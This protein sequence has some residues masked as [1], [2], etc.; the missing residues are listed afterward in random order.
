MKTNNYF[1]LTGMARSGTTLLEKLLCNH[2]DISILSQPFPKLFYQAKK[3]F[4]EKINYPE[5][6]YVLNNLFAEKN[7]TN[8]QLVEF[9]NIS[10]FS[11]DELQL[12]FEEMNNWSGQ[13]TKYNNISKLSQDYVPQNLFKTFQ[14]LLGL[15]HS[16]INA[17]AIGSKEVLI[18]EF[19]PYFLLNKAKVIFIVRDPRDVYTSINYGRG[20]EYGGDHRPSLFHL[21]NWRKSIAVLLS[22]RF[23]ANFLY[24]KYEDLIND[25]CVVLKQ[26][27]DFLEMNPF[28]KNQFED[29]I[30][31]QGGQPWKANSSLPVSDGGIIKTANKKH[32]KYLSPETISYVEYICWPEMKFLGYE[33]IHIQNPLDYNPYKFIE[34]FEIKMHNL[35]LQI[36]THPDN[37]N[38]EKYRYDALFRIRTLSR[39]EQISYFFSTSGFQSLQKLVLE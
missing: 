36:S 13:L 1:I 3:K 25:S 34:P 38:L 24:I 17:K 26:I 4:F 18:E 19:A 21:R 20:P 32:V 37:L 6:Y 5:K 15:N 30:K 28:D 7:Y 27:T 33:P 10:K 39:Q 35:G 11:S 29:G 22:L 8:D 16:H 9:L 23:N 31:D 12:I 2:K 14:H